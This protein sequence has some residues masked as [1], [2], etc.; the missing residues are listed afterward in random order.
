[1]FEYVFGDMY[2]LFVLVFK[3]LFFVILVWFL[4]Y[5]GRLLFFYLVVVVVEI[6]IGINFIDL[7]IL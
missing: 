2:D 5:F 1:M 6:G 7:L 3:L 4:L